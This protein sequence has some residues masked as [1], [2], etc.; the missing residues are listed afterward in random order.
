M[1]KDA[2]RFEPES[3]SGS[4]NGN[5]SIKVWLNEA[6]QEMLHRTASRKPLILGRKSTPDSNTLCGTRLGHRRA[7]GEVMKEGH[8]EA[9]NLLAATQEGGLRWLVSRQR[10]SNICQLVCLARVRSWL[11]C[12]NEKQKALARLNKLLLQQL[13]TGLFME[14]NQNKQSLIPNS[15]RRL[16]QTNV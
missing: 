3:S 12:H 8:L 14:T 4:T 13:D 11:P 15:L 6:P 16:D 7:A 9:T 2:L 10:T 1:L 5:L